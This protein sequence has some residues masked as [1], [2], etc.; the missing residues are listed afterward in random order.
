MITT[1]LIIL[2]YLIGTILL[3]AAGFIFAI[4]CVRIWFMDDQLYNEAKS[5]ASVK[6]L[7]NG[8]TKDGHN[9][10]PSLISN[11]MSLVEKKGQSRQIKK[12]SKLSN[13]NLERWK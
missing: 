2:R 10:D 8:E 5:K 4:G 6:D 12:E 7:I 9:N 1:A 13:H 11:G 3:L